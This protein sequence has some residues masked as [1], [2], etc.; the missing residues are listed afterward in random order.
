MQIHMKTITDT[1]EL[2]KVVEQLKSAEFITVDTE[3]LRTNT[4]YA[5]LCLIQVAD[6][7]DAWA[8]D[9][10]APGIDLTEFWNLMDGGPMKVFHAAR[11]DLEI[12]YQ[13]SGKL[14]TPL[15]DSQLAAMVCG[16]GESVGYE[17]LVRTLTNNDLD[18]TI[19]F[20]DW[21]R[22]P[23][24]EKQLKY[25]IGDVTYLREIY[26]KLTKRL[27]KNNR[28]HWIEEEMNILASPSTYE[29]D[30]RNIWKRLKTRSNNGRFLARVREV[31]AWREREAIR[32]DV[33]RNRI[34]RDES[35]LELCANPPK[36]KEGLVHIRAFPKGHAHGKVGDDIMSALGIAAA[37]PDEDCPRIE[38]GDRKK[39]NAGPIADL[40]K[41]LL[42]I[43]CKNEG[44]APKLVGSAQDIENLAGNPEGDHALMKGWRGEMYGKKAKDLIA[45]KLYIGA[46][47]NDIDIIQASGITTTS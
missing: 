7:D 4:Y 8:I 23:L 20:T 12:F 35:L 6:D 45:G 9:P 24:S 42:K 44:I 19:R 2:N 26:S 43:I 36:E 25:A 22:R 39:E 38:K 3:F 41:L 16:F 11:Q 29:V 34:I 28:Q 1:A 31:A 47:G 32:K 17:T 18:K 30:V 33:P 46:K 27:E 37:I 13:L 21:S 40:L 5:I 14:P 10:M 15:F